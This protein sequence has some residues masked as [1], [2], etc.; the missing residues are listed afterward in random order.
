MAEDQANGQAR[1]TTQRA[2][3]GNGEDVLEMT[4]PETM[5]VMNLLDLTIV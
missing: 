5:T 2:T 4:L 3:P 1:V